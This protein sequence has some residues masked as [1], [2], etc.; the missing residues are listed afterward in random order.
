MATANRS[1]VR[2]IPGPIRL[3]R[4]SAHTEQHVVKVVKLDK[5]YAKPEDFNVLTAETGFMVFF[6]VHY[7]SIHWISS[8]PTRCAE[9]RLRNSNLFERDKMQIVSFSFSNEM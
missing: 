8:P 1:V 5:H 7:Q 4:Q 6:F 2:W 3:E 9:L